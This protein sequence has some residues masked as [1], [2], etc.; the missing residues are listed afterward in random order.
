MPKEKIVLR[1]SILYEVKW[2]LK[3]PSTIAESANSNLKSANARISIAKRIPAESTPEAAVACK[4][5]GV[6]RQDTALLRLALE[7]KE[8]LLHRLQ[9]RV[10]QVRGVRSLG[11]YGNQACLEMLIANE[12]LLTL[13][14]VE[15]GAARVSRQ[16]I[17][18]A[19]PTFTC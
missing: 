17:A 14:M 16:A 2:R 15:H 11:R 13:Q 7:A 10:E 12:A 1:H 8:T 4:N 5:V 9:K 3:V 6:V 18:A 19:N